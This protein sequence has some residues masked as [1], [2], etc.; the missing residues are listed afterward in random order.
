[1]SHFCVGSKVKVTVPTFNK[2]LCHNVVPSSVY[3]FS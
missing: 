3:S 1:M 2:K